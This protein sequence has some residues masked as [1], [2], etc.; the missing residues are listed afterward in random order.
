M[1]LTTNIK[2]I[3]VDVNCQVMLKRHN[4]M[5]K[6]TNDTIDPE[7]MI[8]KY[9]AYIEYYTYISSKMIRVWLK[10]KKTLKK[11]KKKIKDQKKLKKIKNK[12][13][14]KK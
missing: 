3:K 14:Y 12:K 11:N 7:T 4:K 1:G 13:K 5:T 10:N 2:E 6:H 9:N 8:A